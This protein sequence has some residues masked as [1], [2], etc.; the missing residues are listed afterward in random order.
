VSGAVAL[1]VVLL[2]ISSSDA[3]CCAFEAVSMSGEA[4][5]Q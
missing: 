5:I 1:C 2:M 3:R 4:K